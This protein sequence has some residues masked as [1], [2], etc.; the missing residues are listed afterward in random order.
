MGYGDLLKKFSSSDYHGHITKLS[1][2]DIRQRE[3][4]KRRQIHGANFKVG[5]GVGAAV[6]TSGVSLLGSGLGLRQKSIAEQ[7]LAVIQSHMNE[8]GWELHKETKRDKIIPLAAGIVGLAVGGAV[9]FGLSDL[10]TAGAQAA[11]QEGAQLTAHQ[12]VSELATQAIFHPVD[13][14]QGATQGIDT[15]A[16][17]IFASTQPGDLAGNL[18]SATMSHA[19]PIDSSEAMLGGLQAGQEVAM[20]ALHLGADVAAAVA[21]Q[22][23][24]DATMATIETVK[25]KPVQRRE[26]KGAEKSLTVTVT[27]IPRKAMSST[28]Q[29]CQESYETML[30]KHTDVVYRACMMDAR[31]TRIFKGLI[32]AQTKRKRWRK[33]VMHPFDFQGHKFHQDFEMLEAEVTVELEIVERLKT[34]VSIPEGFLKEDAAAWRAS[35]DR[36]SDSI[37]KQHKVL[38]DWLI[39]LCSVRPEEAN[40]HVQLSTIA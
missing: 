17:Q 27:E 35:L 28:V 8:Q 25:R 14:A 22:Q 40:M 34:I 26:K 10:A 3:I 23:L 33:Q 11:V 31:S 18:G 21:T 9:D 32:D 2:Q 16:E 37:V 5:A 39:Y 13:F 19:V 29:N 12:G 38:D 24:A 7:K 30:T 36:L 6:L 15:T 1:E 4:S 20:E